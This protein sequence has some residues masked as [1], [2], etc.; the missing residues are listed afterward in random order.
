LRAAILIDA[1]KI[2]LHASNRGLN[3]KLR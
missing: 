2:T 1:I 3:T